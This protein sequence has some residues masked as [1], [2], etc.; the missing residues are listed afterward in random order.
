MPDNQYG[1]VVQGMVNEWPNQAPS[2]HGVPAPIP[3]RNSSSGGAHLHPHAHKPYQIASRRRSSNHSSAAAERAKFKAQSVPLNKAAQS[4][5]KG[6][7]PME[8]VFDD[9]EVVD[10][11]EFDDA[12][13]QSVDATGQ[14]KK[15]NKGRGQIFKCE[16]CSK[17]Y[18]HAQCLV[19]HRW[20][21]SEHWKEAS[22][23]MLSKH[24]QVQML[25]AAAILIAP[26][27]SLPEDKSY[28]P[29]AVSSPESGLLGSDRFNI[30]KIQASSISSSFSSLYSH[31]DMTNPTTEEDF[32]SPVADLEEFS[33][34]VLEEQGFF[35]GE[36]HFLTGNGSQHGSNGSNDGQAAKQS[37]SFYGRERQTTAVPFQSSTPPIGFFEEQKREVGSVSSFVRSPSHALGNGSMFGS[38]A[39]QD[40]SFTPGSVGSASILRESSERST[41]KED[42]PMEMD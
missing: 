21:H 1:V 17:K 36:D 33:M 29:A 16:K 26:S 7:E 4:A 28:W 38:K 37:G 18:R 14:L 23:L 9:D 11:G 32:T 15:R 24:A 27:R 22:K 6:L 10:D 31:G 25:E 13:M 34:D 5:P 12:E 30:D 20:E 2:A 40:R 19:K 42:I 41:G 8:G 3:I 39:P 35:P